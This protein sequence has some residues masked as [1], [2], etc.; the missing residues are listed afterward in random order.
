VVCSDSA[1]RISSIVSGIPGHL[2]EDV[3]ISNVFVQHR[4]GGT[5]EMAA[6][7]PPELEAAYPE[8]GMFG[9]MPA[10]GLYV[11][12]ARNV[13]VTNFEVVAL[14]PDVRPA[15]VFFDV[16]GAD[17]TNLKMPQ[18]VGDAPYIRLEDVSDFRLAASDHVPDA[19]LER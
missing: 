12:H 10:H 1:S 14:E 5:P 18:A 4:G 9:P 17:L 19:K 2:I 7:V 13:E 3:K 8:P 15:F 16:H 11:R 6:L